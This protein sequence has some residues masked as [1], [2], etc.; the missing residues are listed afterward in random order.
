[1]RPNLFKNS[2]LLVFVLLIGCL[3]ACSTGRR[4]SKQPLYQQQILRSE[5]FRQGFTGFALFDPQQN[6]LLFEHQSHRHFT[7]ASNTKILTLYTLLQLLG[8]SIPS[9]RYEHRGDS[10]LLWGTAYPGFLH[11][12]LPPDSILQEFLRH[13]PGQL[14]YSSQHFQSPPFGPGWAWD[15]Y[16][17]SFQGER[18]A[19][20]IYGNLCRFEQ[21]ST[22]DD[23]QATPSY[24]QDF[25]HRQSP[26][27]GR[28]RIRRHRFHNWF[29]VTGNGNLSDP[30]YRPFRSSDSLQVRLL[31]DWSGQP[32][33][34]LNQP[35]GPTAQTLYQTEVDSLYRRMMYQSDN[36]LAEQLLLCCALQLGD[37]I[38]SR[39]VIEHMQSTHFLDL[40]DPVIWVD[41]SGLS[42]YNLVSPRSMVEVL[43]RLHRLLPEET[44]LSYFPAGGQ[45]GTIQQW[46]A[47]SPPYVFA[48]T[49]TLS[50]QHCLSG[51]LRTF[52]G[53]LLIFSFMH[54]NF[55]GSSRRHKL[56]MEKI[57][58]EIRR[59]Y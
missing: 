51:Y 31:S 9:L 35:L 49:G 17:Y 23:I 56:E 12:H 4:L 1:M 11:P 47:A 52:S 6:K 45:S 3:T 26:K 40:P 18:S 53:R 59:S 32:V 10:L 5:V 38:N 2:K 19:F 28:T 43:H 21:D 57:L 34:L 22:H 7:P 42:R 54:N 48:K 55:P 24:F 36:F 14:F 27:E 58:R 39:S 15:D 46:Y 37:T 44:L 20:P 33:Q 8:D 16:P 41:G 13:A 29:D 50:N 25:I 30:V